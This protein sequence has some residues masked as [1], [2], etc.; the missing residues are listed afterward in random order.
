MAAVVG[1][2][3]EEKQRRPGLGALSTSPN[4]GLCGGST[5]D[6]RAGSTIALGAGA[7]SS[8]DLEETS[9]GQGSLPVP[10]AATTNRGDDR[11][12]RTNHDDE[13]N[14][15]SETNGSDEVPRDVIQ[16]CRRGLQAGMAAKRAGAPEKDTEEGGQDEGKGGGEG[17]GGYN[18]GNLARSHPADAA[19]AATDRR[20]VGDGDSGDNGS[21]GC[22]GGQRRH[23]QRARQH[24]G[25][26]TRPAVTKVM[27]PLGGGSLR[28]K[29]NLRDPALGES[30]KVS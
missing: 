25:P 26:S 10:A 29:Q 18:D 2:E 19:G 21:N 16:D 23:R 6:L 24:E 14:K 5:I 7:V 27:A 17:D 20:R 12:F 15:D 22:G 30:K 8:V 13:A 1:E 11:Y 9:R 4:D 28:E 3:E